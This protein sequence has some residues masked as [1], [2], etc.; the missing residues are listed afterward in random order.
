[1]GLGTDCC[2]RQRYNWA[3][4]VLRR[5]FRD[6]VDFCYPELC[7][8]CKKGCDAGAFLC[9]ACEEAFHEL[10]R[11]AA[12]HRCGA[13]LATDHAPCPFCHGKGVPPLRCVLRIGTFNEP[14][15][16]LIHH[17]KYGRQWGLAEHLARRVIAQKG[18][19]ELLDRAD[20]LVPVPLHFLRQFAR[21]FNQAEIIARQLSVASGKRV[22]RAVSRVRHTPSQTRLSKQERRKNVHKAFRLLNPEA[23]R[24]KHVVLIDDV[25]T[26]GATLQT[27]ARALRPVKPASISAVVL[28]VADPKHRDFRSV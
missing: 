3:V 24:G 17:M 15:K 10:E 2:G 11:H 9:P 6:V 23:I 14:L 26:T 28:A 8:V 19:A 20:V 27:I 22:V 4:L 7:A 21:G 13:P 25:M 5:L 1:M 16:D 18:V 12:C